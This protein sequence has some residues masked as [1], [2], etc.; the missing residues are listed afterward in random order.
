MNWIAIYPEILLLVLACVV[1]LVDLFV[2]DAQHRVS[3]WLTLLGLV[4]IGALCGLYYASG[5]QQFAM[6]RALIVDTVI[7]TIVTLV[8]SRRYA[9][10]R[11]MWGGELFS[12]VLLSLLGQFIMISGNNL[13]T[14]YL[15]LELLSLALYALVA[16]RRDHTQSTEAAMKYFILGALAS[17]FL[18]YGMSML[19]GATGSLDLVT[20][21]RMI[22][23]E[24]INRAVLVLG[25]V[26]IVAG[27][28]FKLGAV[29][30]HMWI[31][32]VYQG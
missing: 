27:L 14:I 7:A 16:L 22:A 32:D 29:P 13:L 19:Y 10:D 4:G 6:A 5:M 26:F 8:Y 18:L 20:I 2:K 31:P 24:P 12:L 17:G 21:F 28:A 3:Y 25:V 23:V 30:F 1:M 15:G 11:G 9:L